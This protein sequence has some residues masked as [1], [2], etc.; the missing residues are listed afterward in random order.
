MKD[1]SKLVTLVFG[2]SFAIAA[3]LPAARAA[4]PPTPSPSTSGSAVA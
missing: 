3:W 1:H 2:L 4:R